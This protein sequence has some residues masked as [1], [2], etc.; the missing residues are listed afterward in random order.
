MSPSV[1]LTALSFVMEAAA[2]TL[3]WWLPC[4]P[5]GLWSF[6]SLLDREEKHL[7]VNQARM[8]WESRYD[9]LKVI[10]IWIPLWSFRCFCCFLMLC[11]KL[12]FANL[13]ESPDCKWFSQSTWMVQGGVLVFMGKMLGWLWPLG[14]VWPTAVK[15]GHCRWPS[16]SQSVTLARFL[17]ALTKD[18]QSGLCK[19]VL[20]FSPGL[21]WHRFSLY[22]TA[23][24]VHPAVTLFA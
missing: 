13:W 10:F 1:C 22:Q 7:P 11:F 17:T 20:P 18:T 14:R 6:G 15:L 23:A 9:P 3:E 4:L 5:Q 12:A 24:L 16:S 2:I 19:C 8:G 21:G